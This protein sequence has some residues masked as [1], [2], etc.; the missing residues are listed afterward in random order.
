MA[1]VAWDCVID[2]ASLLNI[3]VSSDHRQRGIARALVDRSVTELTL[4]GVRRLH[5]EVRESNV[6]A[7]ALYRSRGFEVLGRRAAYY[8]AAPGE[9]REDALVMRRDVA[10]GERPRSVD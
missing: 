9:T 10:D 2:E 7:I 8:A 3:T 5:L 1:F 6:A 4:R